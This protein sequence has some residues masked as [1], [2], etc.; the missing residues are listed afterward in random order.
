M[1]NQ[2]IV[3]GS[4]VSPFVRKVWI[5]LRLK[6]LDFEIKEMAPFFEAHKEALLKLNPLGKIPVYQEDNFTLADSSVICAYLEKQYPTPA[7]YPS[8]PK[9]YAQC[10]WF[11]EYADTVLIPTVNTIFFNKILA[12]KFNRIPDEAAIK[13]ASEEKIPEIFNYLEQQINNKQYLIG[14]TLSLADISTV[15][16]FLNLELAGLPIDNT[17]W[18][19]LSTYVNQIVQEPVIQ[20]S[21]TKAQ[22]R[23]TKK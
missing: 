4:I 17:R 1:T 12:R 5:S 11:E 21:F 19:A 14:S 20:E 9:D 10:L 15:V 16:A 6:H 2:R 8:E 22:E 18:D 23:L 3:Y 7:L 13:I